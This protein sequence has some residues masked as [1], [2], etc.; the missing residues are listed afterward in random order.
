MKM[1]KTME[2]RLVSDDTMP[3][4][5]ITMTEDDEPKI[6]INTNHLIW[7][8]LHRKTIAGSTQPLFEKL[9]MLL[10]N[11]LTE[12]RTNETMYGEEGGV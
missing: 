3:P 2:F 5:V 8:S 10:T 4:I 1:N 12:Q 9:D 7:L 6:V 11:F